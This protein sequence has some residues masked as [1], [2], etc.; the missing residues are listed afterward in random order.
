MPGSIQHVKN[1]QKTKFTYLLYE[2]S[3]GQGWSVAIAMDVDVAL[4][5][6]AIVGMVVGLCMV[7]VVDVAMGTWGEEN[8]GGGE[9]KR[10]KLNRQC[11]NI[12]TLKFN[13]DMWCWSPL[14]I[15]H[16]MQEKD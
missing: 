14:L 3:A 4:L 13:F 16:Y 7:M 15:P 11:V 6:V 5:G 10:F 1:N 12:Q 2:P 8:G 9:E